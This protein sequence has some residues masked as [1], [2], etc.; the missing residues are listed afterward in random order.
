MLVRSKSSGRPGRCLGVGAAVGMSKTRQTCPDAVLS[1][2]HTMTDKIPKRIIQTDKSRNLPVLQ[3]A[4]VTGIRLNNPDFEYVF[5][6]DLQVDT[7]IDRHC[8]EYRDVLNSF[9]FA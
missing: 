5:F 4:A 8:P 2:R 6:D 1:L 7:F 9:P 3:K